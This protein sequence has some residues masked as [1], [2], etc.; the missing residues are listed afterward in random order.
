[1]RESTWFQVVATGAKGEVSSHLF[2]VEVVEAVGEDLV[3]AVGVGEGDEAESPAPLGRWVLHHH[4]LRD[5]PELA[6]VLLQALCKLQD[7]R[8]VC[9]QSSG[10]LR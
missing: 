9:L 8:R 5:V 2:P 1:M 3:D 6:E 10:F 4:H 7:G